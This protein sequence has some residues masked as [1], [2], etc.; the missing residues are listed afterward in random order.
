MDSGCVAPCFYTCDALN[1]KGSYR[2]RISFFRP[3]AWFEVEYPK[4]SCWGIL[5]LCGL[6]MMGNNGVNCI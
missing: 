4:I 2:V 5:V 3:A 1:W 6:S